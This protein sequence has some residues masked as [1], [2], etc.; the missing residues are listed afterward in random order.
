M[1]TDSAL[2]IPED[3]VAQ[4]QMSL[5]GIGRLVELSQEGGSSRAGPGRQARPVGDFFECI[6]ILEQKEIRLQDPLQGILAN[7]ECVEET[8]ETIGSIANSLRDSIEPVDSLGEGLDEIRRRIEPDHGGDQ[9]AET[10]V[11]SGE[12]L[13]DASAQARVLFPPVGGILVP[14]IARDDV[15]Q[16]L[17]ES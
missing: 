7:V 12:S 13:E 3:L 14:L 4:D 1:I 6:Q 9:G 11:D 17:E 2:A 10:R 5:E 16:V 8:A 15:R